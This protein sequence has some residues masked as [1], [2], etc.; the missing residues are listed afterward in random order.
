MTGNLGGDTTIEQIVAAPPVTDAGTALAPGNGGLS[1]ERIYRLDAPGVVQITATSVETQTDPFG[2]FPPTSE[3]RQAL[4]SGFVID[5]A[6]HI[7]TN[8][9]V[10]AGAQK[11]QVS[12]SGN[13]EIDATVIGK[14]PATDVAVLQVDAHSRS[15]TPL[16]L[17]R[18]RRGS[19]RRPGGRDRQPVQPHPDRHRGHRERSSADDRRAEQRLDDRPRDPDRCRDQPRQLGR[20]ADQ[21]AR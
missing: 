6:G 1:V 7:V 2:F 3:T 11:V 5:K 4:G 14:D 9:H 16:P 10:I 13:D 8:N 12:F 15:L 18:L 17:G 20:A 21:R 19:G